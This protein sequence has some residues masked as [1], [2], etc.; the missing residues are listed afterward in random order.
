MRN[1]T[2]YVKFNALIVGTIFVCG[3]LAASLFLYSTSTYMNH[4]L[5]TSG[6]ELAASISQVISNDILVDDRFAMTE[7][8]LHAQQTNDQVRYILVT[9]PDG[10]IL[11]STFT[12]G[13][14]KGL[15]ERRDVQHD[16]AD[17]TVTFDS[18]EGY[19][20][21]VIYPIDGGLVGYFRI[22]LSERPMMQLMWKRFVQTM[23]V[24]LAI[25]LAASVLATRYARAFLRPVQTL[26]QAIRQIGRGNYS[27]R[28]PVETKDEVGRLAKA[29]NVMSDRLAVKD[30]E[31]SKLLTALRE[32]EKT[33]IWL[34]DQLFS[35]REDERRRI[36]R[37]LHDETSQ[38]MVSM[39]AYLRL[40][41]DQTEEPKV[42]ELVAG[43]RDLTRETLEGLRHLA[44][45]LHPPLLDDLGLVV[46]IEKYLDTYRQTQ[47]G[48]TVTFHHDG[49]ISRVSRPVALFCYR[50]VQEGLTNIAR[51]AQAHTVTIGLHV[52]PSKLTLSVRDDGIGFSADRAERARLDNHLGLV[53]MRERTDVLNGTFAID[54][55]PGKGTTLTSSLPLYLSEEEEHEHSLG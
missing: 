47:P 40:I 26:A 23:L 11:A 44:V 22:G 49:D 7:Q 14:P 19:I 36:S 43:V 29:F 2:L 41:M 37:E 42:R 21:E 17:K 16:G 25:C 3:L 28:V 30:R 38:S 32:K 13:L 53:S 18:T 52:L 31:N 5:D 45:N 4:E 34:I 51:H 24:I 46:A 48:L 54:S 55:H 20:R 27:V 39:L 1:Y 6:R 35:A 8:L 12:D 50:M 9:Y 33:R 15:P 10:R